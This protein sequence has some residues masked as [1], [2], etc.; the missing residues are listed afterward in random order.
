[1]VCLNVDEAVE[2]KRDG[3]GT[4]RSSNGKVEPDGLLLHAPVSVFVET[5][6]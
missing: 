1:M 4:A 2:G 5:K 6:L 3:E